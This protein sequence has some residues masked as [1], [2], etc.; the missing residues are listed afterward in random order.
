M[1]I[2]PS[3]KKLTRGITALAAVFNLYFADTQKAIAEEPPVQNKI[4]EPAAPEEKPFKSL[5]LYSYDVLRGNYPS[6]RLEG[7]TTDLPGKI[8]LYSFVDVEASKDDESTFNNFLELRLF[9]TFYEGL[10]TV[11]ELNAFNGGTGVGRLGI[12]YTPEIRDLFFALRLFPLQTGE[13]GNSQFGVYARKDF[14]AGFLEGLLEYNHFKDI[15]DVVYGEIQ[16]GIKLTDQ[17]SAVGQLRYDGFSRTK[18]KPYA[19]LAFNF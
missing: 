10:G 16:G 5:T 15:E 17:L 6:A 18:I 4:T 2:K 1:K 19:G 13:L 12:I 7:L 11:A 8:T 14:E 9:K 3:I